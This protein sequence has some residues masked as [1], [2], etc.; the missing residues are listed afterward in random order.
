VTGVDESS[1]TCVVEFRHLGHQK[2]K[3]QKVGIMSSEG[4]SS[5]IPQGKF[6]ELTNPR[7]SGIREPSV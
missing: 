7:V 2:L 1:H 6:S 4:A 3:N 5:E